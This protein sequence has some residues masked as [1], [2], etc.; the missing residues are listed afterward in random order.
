MRQL[1][2]RMQ[3]RR[4]RSRLD[5]RL[6]GLALITLGVGP[7]G[8]AISSLRYRG[9]HPMTAPPSAPLLDKLMWIIWLLTLASW[10]STALLVVAKAWVGYAHNWRARRDGAGPS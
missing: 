7:T 8:Y 6:T 1:A 4:S 3:P 10:C 9:A 5:M 2:A